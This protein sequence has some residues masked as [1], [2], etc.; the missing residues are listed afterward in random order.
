MR[1]MVPIAYAAAEKGLELEQRQVEKV[2]AP[3]AR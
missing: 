1:S 3:P 2:R